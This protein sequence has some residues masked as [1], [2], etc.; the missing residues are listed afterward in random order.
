MI[1][2]IICVAIAILWFEIP[3]RGSFYC[4]LLLSLYLI[5]ALGLGLLISTFS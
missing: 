2:M 3:F 5:P 4:Y 1:S